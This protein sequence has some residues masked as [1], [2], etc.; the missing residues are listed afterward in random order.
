MEVILLEKVPGKGNLGDI[1]RVRD[2]HARNW[3]IPQK[4]ARRATAA[5][6]QEFEARRAEL[7]KIQAE[8]LAAAQSVGERLSGQ[9]VKILQK[10]GVDGRLFGSV[11]SADIVEALRKAGFDTV[12]KAQ[13]RL[14]AGPL[15]AVGE[16]SVQVALHADVVTDVTIVIEGD[17]A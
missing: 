14:P 4:M 11:T 15:K 16:Y 10:A 1:V 13:V 6:K 7:E 17:I 9:Q 12:E 5:A 8:K 2:G 3:L